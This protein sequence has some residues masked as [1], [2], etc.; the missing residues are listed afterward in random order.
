VPD[1]CTYDYAIVRV[2]PQVERGEFINAG[3]ILVCASR[4]FLKAVI[5]LDEAGLCFLD[6]AADVES[7]NAALSAIPAI[8]AGGAGGGPIGQLPL[9]ARFDWLVAPRSTSVQVSPVHSGR[10]ADLDAALDRLMERMVRRP[11]G[12]VQPTCV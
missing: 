2:V 1:L 11:G 4:G 9:R 3:V 5:E 10:C 12:K 6:P 8:C 7:F